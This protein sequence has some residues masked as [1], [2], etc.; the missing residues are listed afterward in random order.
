MSIWNE[1][2]QQT[3]K[4]GDVLSLYDSIYRYN[5]IIEALNIGLEDAQVVLLGLGMQPEKHT[6]DSW[7]FKLWIEDHNYPTFKVV[8]DVVD[9]SPPGRSTSILKYSSF[10]VLNDSE[11]QTMESEWRHELDGI[12]DFVD[13]NVNITTKPVVEID[14][15]D[16]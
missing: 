12:L 13:E 10:M 6:E 5:K 1:L 11:L 2:H 15:K 14:G 3:I 8:D 4:E 9:N 7:L 16:M